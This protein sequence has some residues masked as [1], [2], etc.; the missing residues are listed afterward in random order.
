MFRKILVPLDGSPLAER[1][2]LHVQRL[3]PPGTAELILV[4]V[5][6]TYR[7]SYSATDM[8]LHNTLSHARSSTDVY[9]QA[10]RNQWEAQHYAVQTYVAEGDA[11]QEILRMADETGADLIAMTT[12]GRAG[13]RRWSLGSVA[14]RVLREAEQPVWLVRES[15][16]VVSLREMQRILVPLDGT[17]AARQA[18]VQAQQLARESGA[19]VWLLRAI[20]KRDEIGRA[21]PFVDDPEKKLFEMWQRHAEEDLAE[22]AQELTAAGIACQTLVV[23]GEPAPVIDDT[24]RTENV[25]CIVMATHVRQGLDRLLYGNVADEVVRRCECPMLLVHAHEWST[26]VTEAQQAAL[27]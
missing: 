10:Q 17:A 7:Y 8:A 9:L 22:V 14:E 12:H 11:A 4:S 15:T 13:I 5:I 21:A 18:V 16:R 3:A 27:A 2:L 26:P 25:D 19:E 23:P 1:A 24:A 6:E 20:P